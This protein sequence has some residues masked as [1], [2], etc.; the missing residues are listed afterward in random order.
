MLLWAR[1][2][3]APPPTET[4]GAAETADAVP[5]PPGPPEGIL[6]VGEIARIEQGPR[7]RPRVL[8]EGGALLLVTDT[9]SVELYRA[10]NGEF[11]WKLGLPGEV[12]HLPAVLGS[13]PLE[14]LLSTKSGKLLFVEGATGS[15]TRELELGFEIALAPFVSR[16]AA[17]GPTLFLGTATGEVVAYDPASESERFRVETPEKPNA[18]AMARDTLVVSGDARTLTA[19]DAAGGTIRWRRP[20]RAGFYAPAVFS[21]RADRLYVG[22]EAGEFYCLNA[23]NGETHFRWSTGAAVRAPAF[24]H[25]NRVYVASYGNI[26]YA[27]DAGGGSEQWRANLPGRPATGPVL[28]NQRL[29]V[30]TFDGVF[31]EV[32]LDTGEIS[33]Q[34]TAP[35][36]L[37]SAPSFAVASPDAPEIEAAAEPAIE[38]EPPAPRWFERHRVALPLRT[39]AVLLLAH[40]PPDPAGV[41]TPEVKDAKERKP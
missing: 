27:Y 20:A 34:Y 38:S 41:E 32:S 28:V 6:P 3:Q 5:V 18:F 39:G 36:E 37:G 4:P 11:R 10:E 1:A 29:V 9:G 2:Q 7:E 19:L 30:A 15:I 8:L 14:L 33:K 31:V 35:G 13:D 24:V 26:L 40:Q 21:E 12:L 23:S 25:G 22:D 17:F 16:D